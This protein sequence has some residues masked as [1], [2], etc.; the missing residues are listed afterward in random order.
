MNSL[1]PKIY[2]NPY[3]QPN[4]ITNLAEETPAFAAL[5]VSPPS[6]LAVHEKH[7]KSIGLLK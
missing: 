3:R 4:L 7:L 5:S 1:V 6:P 2:I